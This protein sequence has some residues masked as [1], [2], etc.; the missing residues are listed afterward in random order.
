M[1]LG[2][3]FSLSIVFQGDKALFGR[4]GGRNLSQIWTM[5]ISTYPTVCVIKLNNDLSLSPLFTLVKR[6][7]EIINNVISGLRRALL[8]YYA[9]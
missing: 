2:A 9:A 5:H 6:D 8:R 4:E 7:K 3:H 1:A